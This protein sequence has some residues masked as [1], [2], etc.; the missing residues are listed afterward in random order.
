MHLHMIIHNAHLYN[1][2][3]VIIKYLLLYL[4]AN[5]ALLIV[6]NVPLLSAQNVILV[7][8]YLKIQLNV[9]HLAQVFNSLI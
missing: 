4:L 9:L 6:Y 8:Y 3:K 2:L 5:H 7:G 1:V